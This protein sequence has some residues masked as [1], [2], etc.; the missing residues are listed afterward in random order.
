MHPFTLPRHLYDPLTF[1]QIDS[2]DVQDVILKINEENLTILICCEFAFGSQAQGCNIY[3]TINHTEHHQQQHITRNLTQHDATSC[4]E[5]NDINPGISYTI[6]VYDWERDGS[7]ELRKPVYSAAVFVNA[8]DEDH[9]TDRSTSI[10]TTEAKTE[11]K[12]EG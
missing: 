12:K 5:E 4:W 1:N 3:I 9:N 7:I 6:S 8:S 11:P 2:F 10:T